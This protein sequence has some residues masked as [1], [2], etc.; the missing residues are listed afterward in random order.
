MGALIDTLVNRSVILRIRPTGLHWLPSLPAHED[1]CAHGGAVIEVDGEVFFDTRDRGLTLSAAALF[2]LR[3]LERDHLPDALAGDQLFP[4][5]GHAVFSDGPGLDV[6]VSGCP[7]GDNVWVRHRGTMVE[8]ETVEGE[9][10][11]VS[12]AEWQEAVHSFADEIRDF[13]DASAPK[14]PTIPGERE[15]WDAFWAEWRRRRTGMRVA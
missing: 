12:G 14:R 13:Y 9:R 15:G 1:L 3:T 10:V 11:E 4:C 7:N 2:L 5:C 6:Y 8:L